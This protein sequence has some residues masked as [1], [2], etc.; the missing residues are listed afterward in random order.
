MY[1]ICP[2]GGPG[3]DDGPLPGADSRLRADGRLPVGVAP[4]GHCRDVEALSPLLLDPLK[5][6]D[7]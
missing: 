3:H 1:L 7:V 6:E 4:S 5:G 2:S